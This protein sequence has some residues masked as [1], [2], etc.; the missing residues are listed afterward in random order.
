MC[1]GIPHSVAICIGRRSQLFLA[2]VSACVC[3]F[4]NTGRGESGKCE[5]N[6]I[7][8][9]PCQGSCFVPAVC[10]RE[11]QLVALCCDVFVDGH[12]CQ[13]SCFVS[14]VCCD[15]VVD[16]YSCQ[17]YTK[18]FVFMCMVC[19]LCLQCLAVYCSVLHCVAMT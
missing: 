9:H 19:A 14:A 7:D 2:C 3:I 6:E 8:G 17:G 4:C 18:I 1:C 5:D 10:C 16:G 15:I 12:S 11:L 13:G